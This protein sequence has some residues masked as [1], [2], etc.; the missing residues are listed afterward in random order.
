MPVSSANLK[1]YLSGGSGN[2][3]PNA[4]LGGARS[5]TLVAT[6]LNNLFD[7]VTGSES[8]AGTSEFRCLYFR[9]EDADADG[10][11]LPTVW[12]TSNT[13]SA[14]T[15]MSMGLDPAGK[16]GT[17]TT[18]ANE[19]AVPA[20]V[21]F[22][23]PSTKGAGL[24]LPSGPYMQNDYVAIWLRR[25]VSPGTSSASTDPSTIRVEGDTV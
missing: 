2:T 6:S 24:L 22:S 18:I 7:D 8:T 21:T 14:G 16:N 10:L 1:F 9:N 5:T 4:S 3:N 13:P 23:T 25:V 19:L 12:F 20:G 15:V 17:A 11:I